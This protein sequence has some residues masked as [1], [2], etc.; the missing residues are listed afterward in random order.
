MPTQQMVTM[1][2]VGGVRGRI[3]R[4]VELAGRFPLPGSTTWRAGS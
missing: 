3:E 4:A 1:L 2:P